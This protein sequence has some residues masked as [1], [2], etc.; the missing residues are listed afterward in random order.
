[1]GKYVDLFN[2][3]S[4]IIDK[5]NYYRPAFQS[6]M[7]SPE[8]RNVEISEDLGEFMQQGYFFFHI[9]TSRK[10]FKFGEYFFYPST[11]R[12]NTALFMIF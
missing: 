1:M 7:T 9:L 11:P 8:W 3:W 12:V 10:S 5:P 6:Y 4:I 2:E